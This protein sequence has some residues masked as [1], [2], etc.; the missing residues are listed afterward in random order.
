MIPTVIAN[1]H[2]R[3]CVDRRECLWRNP[4]PFKQTDYTEMVKKFIVLGERIA[5]SLIKPLIY[6]AK[7][8]PNGVVHWRL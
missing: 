3:R 2:A 7:T 1:Q 8:P 5:N 6:Q 4:F